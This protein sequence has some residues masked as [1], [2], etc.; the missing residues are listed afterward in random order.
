MTSDPAVK[1]FH[2]AIIGNA[3]RKLGRD[4]TPKELT[5]IT[6]RGGFI[7]LETILNTVNAEPKDYVEKYL[8]SE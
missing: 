1:S 2:A 8:N 7:A 3:K 5:F 6:Y 4:L